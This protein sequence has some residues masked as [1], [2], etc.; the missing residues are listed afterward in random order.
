[1]NAV[2]EENLQSRRDAYGDPPKPDYECG[3]S[4]GTHLKQPEFAKLFDKPSLGDSI[5]S[6]YSLKAPRPC[7]SFRSVPMPKQLGGIFTEEKWMTDV[8]GPIWQ[9]FDDAK[10]KTHQLKA[11]L[12]RN[13]RMSWTAK[14]GYFVDLC[15]STFHLSDC[16]LLQFIVAWLLLGPQILLGLLGL[17]RRI[18]IRRDTDDEKQWMRDQLRDLSHLEP[19]A[20]ENDIVSS[21]KDIADKLTRDY[22]PALKV[23]YWNG[24]RHV[25]GVG[26]DASFDTD[27]FML[28]FYISQPGVQSNTSV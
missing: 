5:F 11:V 1:M 9:T 27:D 3:I 28:F 18:C 14:V 24:L 25:H 19:V 4:I 22:A 12:I 10:R 16:C 2:S 26:S 20:I 15:F 23:E 8:V 6:R 21:L 13:Y 7:F 17:L